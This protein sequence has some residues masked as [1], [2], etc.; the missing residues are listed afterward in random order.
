MNEEKTVKTLIKNLITFI[1]ATRNK[2]ENNS[3]V[4]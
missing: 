1:F 4:F 3:F 2:S